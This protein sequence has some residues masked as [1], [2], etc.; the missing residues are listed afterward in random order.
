[1]PYQDSRANMT[2]DQGQYAITD[3]PVF[4]I[5]VKNLATNLE[6]K[7][8]ST[9]KKD[10]GQIT[11]K[12]T[13][14]IGDTIKGKHSKTDK[15]IYGKIVELNIDDIVIIDENDNKRKQVDRKTCEKIEK[16][17][18]SKSADNVR[19]TTI[20]SENKFISFKDFKKMNS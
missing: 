7:P 16:K 2:Q 8:D 12:K 13:F 10:D 1:M 15:W 11:N 6:Q 18:G 9:K 3:N 4:K 5:S 20:P 14:K 19:I 17:L